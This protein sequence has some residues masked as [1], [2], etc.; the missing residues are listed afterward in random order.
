MAYK[1]KKPVIPYIKGA[2]TWTS[3]NAGVPILEE[4]NTKQSV[5]VVLK[6]RSIA[7]KCLGYYHHTGGY[8]LRQSHLGWIRINSRCKIL[9]A[10]LPL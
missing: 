5:T 2:D 1:P 8:W 10:Y 3:I 9:W 4:G 6:G 7:A